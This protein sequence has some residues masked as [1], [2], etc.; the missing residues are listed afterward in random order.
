[1]QG[2]RAARASRRPAGPGAAAVAA[3]PPCLAP[4]LDDPT[5]ITVKHWD[6]LLDGAL[7]AASSRLDWATLLQR[8]HGLDALVCPACDGR[9]RAI[10]TIADPDVARAILRHLGLR[11][12]PLPRARAR[13]P[14]GQESLHFDA[15]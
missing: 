2:A 7:Y 9:L 3:P 6:R 8:T 13:D 5:F 11:A 15:A 10:A 14:T 4:P 1:V 12:E